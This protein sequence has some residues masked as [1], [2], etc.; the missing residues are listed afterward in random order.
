MCP[1][2]IHTCGDSHAEKFGAS[3]HRYEL[4]TSRLLL[5]YK[6][7]RCARSLDILNFKSR[8]SQ[9]TCRM[10]FEKLTLQCS[11]SLMALYG[12]HDEELGLE[13]F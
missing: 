4:A 1:C 2:G 11:H 8:E 3:S 6:G 12:M 13:Y 7:H 10:L 9:L 5:P